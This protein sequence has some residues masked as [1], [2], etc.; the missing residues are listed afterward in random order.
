MLLDQTLSKTCF[1]KTG[2]DVSVTITMTFEYMLST[3][4]GVTVS[5]MMHIAYIIFKI[6]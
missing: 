3:L 1:N 6:K 2:C 4:L 5:N